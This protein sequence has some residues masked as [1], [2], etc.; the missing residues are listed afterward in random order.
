LARG[1]ASTVGRSEE[2][3]ITL[4]W[5]CLNTAYGSTRSRLGNLT[6]SVAGI[7]EKVLKVRVQRIVWW[8]FLATDDLLPMSRSIWP[9]ERMVFPQP[10]PALAAATRVAPNFQTPKVSL[11]VCRCSGNSPLGPIGVGDR[12]LIDAHPNSPSLTS[13]SLYVASPAA[14]GRRRPCLNQGLAVMLPQPPVA[15]TAIGGGWLV[16]CCRYAHDNDHLEVECARGARPGGV[17]SGSHAC[18]PG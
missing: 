9:Q 6:Q 11:I 7:A 15:P 13:K 16:I 1:E 18:S 12:S 8:Y 5:A 14:D 10:D 2:P 3:R 17:Q 4:A